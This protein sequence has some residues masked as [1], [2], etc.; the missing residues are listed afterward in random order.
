MKRQADSEKAAK[1]AQRAANAAQKAQT[2]AAKKAVAAQKAQAK[3]DELE[4]SAR[5]Q[6]KAALYFLDIE[7]FEW[8]FEEAMFA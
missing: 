1:R 6:A 3:A 4:E 2:T 5:F 7:D 8:N